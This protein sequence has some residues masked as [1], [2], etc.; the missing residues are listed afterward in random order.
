M[1]APGSL[2]D[3]DLTCGLRTAADRGRRRHRRVSE[4]IGLVGT[5]R[6]SR[7]GTAGCRERDGIGP[8]S[9]ISNIFGLNLTEPTNSA[10][11]NW[12]Q[13][14]ASIPRWAKQPNS[15]NLNEFHPIL[16][17]Q[18]GPTGFFWVIKHAYMLILFL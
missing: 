4:V 5:H 1:V 2:G 18:T 7:C 13:F 8:I 6:A 17:K 3:G 11:W 12:I 9:S 10:G 14:R 16:T 15:R